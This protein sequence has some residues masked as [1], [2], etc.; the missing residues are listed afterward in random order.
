MFAQNQPYFSMK[1]M[2]LSAYGSQWKKRI[3]AMFTLYIDDSGTA[4]EQPIAIAA[5][6]LIPAIRLERF[7]REWNRFL[8]KEGIAAY[9]FHSSECFYR[10]PKSVFADWTDEGVERVFFRVLQIFQKYAIKAFCIATNK[11]DY[12][13]LMPED[14]RVGVSK[15]HFVWAL[16]SVLGMSYDWSTKRSAPMEYVFDLTDKET[17]RDITEAIDYSA[18]PHIGYGDHYTAHHS[19]CSRKEVPGL[20]VADFFAW[21]CYQAACESVIKKP[22]PELVERIWAAISPDISDEAEQSRIAIQRLSR[23]GL[24]AW[25]K[26]TY[27]SPVDLAVREYRQKRKEARMPRRKNAILAETANKHKWKDN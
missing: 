9:G 12:D 4:H 25:V 24:V 21:L 8:E 23:D 7:E 2:L 16:S 22:V 10:N 26:R 27:G 5:G 14:M 17:K 6:V 3:I 18:E 11:K 15:N 1:H 19:F 20:Q 13:E